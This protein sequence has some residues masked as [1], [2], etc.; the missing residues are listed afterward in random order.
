[1]NNSSV[2]KFFGESHLYGLSFTE[3]KVLGRMTEGLADKEIAYQLGSS[4]FTINKHVT[5]ILA[6]M[7]ARSRTEAAVRAIREGLLPFND[8]GAQLGNEDELLLYRRVLFDGATDAILVTNEAGCYTDANPAAEELL[9]LPRERLLQMK[10]FDVVAADVSWTEAEFQKFL[11]DRYWCGQVDLKRP[12]GSVVPVE[13]RAMAVTSPTGLELGLSVL[14]D[15]SD[16][17]TLDELRTLSSIRTLSS[18]GVGWRATPF[19]SKAA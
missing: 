11:H 4:R 13:A 9:R 2:G 3:Q 18:E 16:E 8:E 14:R 12:D 10:V 6:K 17:K 1:M 19:A 15:L 7:A 5:S